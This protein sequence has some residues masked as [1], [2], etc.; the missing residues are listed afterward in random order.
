MS[1]F[2]LR[3]TDVTAFTTIW[4][5]TPVRRFSLTGT[6][7]RKYTDLMPKIYATIGL[8][9]CGKSTL[10]TA[11]C[12]DG[13]GMRANRDDI[14]FTAFGVYFGPPIDENAV[15]KIQDA[16]VAEILEK[17]LDVWID[18][19]NLTPRAKNHC[20][21]LAAKHGVPLVWIDLTHVPVET[22]I[23]RDE[24]RDRHVGEEVI[25]SMFNKWIRPYPYAGGKP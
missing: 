14:R 11:R 15:T 20:S 16:T 3:T 1:V 2:A 23:Q 24:A 18:D 5:V 8:P 10:A 13:S 6:L 7:P 21:E 19:T 12:S 9:G 25:T 4:P 17:G 22:C